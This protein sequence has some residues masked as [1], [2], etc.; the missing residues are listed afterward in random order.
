MG[1]IYLISAISLVTAFILIKKSDKILD[2]LSFLGISIVVFFSYNVFLCYVLTFVSIPNSLIVLSIMNFIITAIISTIIL[3]KKQIQKYKFDKFNLLCVL[4]ILFVTFIASCLN[5]GLPFN[6]K[7]E[8]GDPSVHYLTSIEFAEEERL[9]NFYEDDA[10]GV[11][12]GRKIG[13]YVN[14]GI[15][16]KCFSDVLEEIDYFNVFIAFGIFILFLTGAIMFNTLE[17]YTNSKGGKILALIVS[18]LY[19]LG[20]PYNSLLFGFEY[21][22]MGILLLRNIAS[23]DILF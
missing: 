14:S 13:S 22:S 10:Y 15:I 2:I 7:Y 12:V 17:K 3:K 16:M 5:F 8:T 11:S 9:L 20:Y 1:I 18:I 6:I 23:Y 21:L 4:I 19:V